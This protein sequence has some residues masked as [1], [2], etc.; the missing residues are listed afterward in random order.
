MTTDAANGLVLSVDTIHKAGSTTDR[1]EPSEAIDSLQVFGFQGRGLVPS[2][3]K[4]ESTKDDLEDIGRLT[5]LF[6]G[7]ENLRKRGGDAGEEE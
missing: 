4:F 1:R 6:Y 7:L 5:S 3:T 2:T